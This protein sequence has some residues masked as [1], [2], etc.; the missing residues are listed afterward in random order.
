MARAEHVGAGAPLPDARKATASVRKRA[1][2]GIARRIVV[3]WACLIVMFLAIWTFLSPSTSVHPRQL[4]PPP[5]AAPP[6]DS[7]SSFLVFAAAFALLFAWFVFWS[8]RLTRKLLAA[9]RLLAQEDSG[10][11]ERAFMALRKS[12][13]PLVA[14]Q[15]EFMLAQLEQRR[16]YFAEA[17]AL[18]DKSIR[19]VA[20]NAQAAWLLLPQA[21]TERA[22]LLAMLDRSE[23]A[24][25]ELAVLVAASPTFPHLAASQVRVRLVQALRAGDL[26]AARAISAQRTRDMPLPYDDELLADIASLSGEERPAEEEIQRIRDELRV[27]GPLRAWF[28]AAWPDGERVLD[29]A[30]ARAAGAP[31]VRSAGASRAVNGGNVELAADGGEDEGAQSRASR[32]AHT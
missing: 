4:P 19:R 8:Q 30:A 9:N 5:T 16:G 6:G 13:N 15:A 27:D 3:L 32:S 11:A 12:R 1:G 14:A 31:R 2:G 17:L 10:P 21:Q 20:K 25:S 29:E 22:R 7:F 23:E 26:A 24:T 28:S 18:C